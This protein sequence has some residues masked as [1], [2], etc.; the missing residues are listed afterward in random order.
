MNAGFYIDGFNLYHAIDDLNKPW[1]KWICYRKLAESLLRPGHQISHVKLFT[2]Y[3]TWLPDSRQRHE[4]YLKAASAM[5][6]EV[7][8][9]EFKEKKSRCHS[10]KAKW[11]SHE[12]KESD[13]NA[14]IHM[15]ADALIG[16]TEVVYLVSTDSDMA[17]AVKMIRSECNI[18]V[19]SVRTPG[20][21]A[22]REITH[23]AT[24]NLSISEA[25]L[26]SCLLPREVSDLGGKIVATRPVEY[27][28]PK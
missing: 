18:P 11:M 4:I 23:Y 25:M 17:P 9:G 3:A 8:L 13:V 15:I 24:S 26:E 1:L 14:C 10:C 22:S 21:R 2:A 6:V 27:D 19:I 20:R 16:P 12:E 5:G 28:P 7:I